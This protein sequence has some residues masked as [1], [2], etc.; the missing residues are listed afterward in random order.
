M[1]DVRVRK[2][3]EQKKRV[4]ILFTLINSGWIGTGLCAV[5]WRQ[6]PYVSYFQASRL[7]ILVNCHS[8]LLTQSCFFAGKGFLAVLMAARCVRLP[9][10]ERVSVIPHCAV[11][12]IWLPCCLSSC[13]LDYLIVQLPSPSAGCHHVPPDSLFSLTFLVQK[14]L[15]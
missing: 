15:L 7:L 9:V 14:H 1:W 13:F 4:R 2:V 11:G 12:A 10:S 3:Y 8:V 5:S 6:W